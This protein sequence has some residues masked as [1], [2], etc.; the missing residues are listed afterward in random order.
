MHHYWCTA[1]SSVTWQCGFLA[2]VFKILFRCCKDANLVLEESLWGPRLQANMQLMESR[3]YRVDFLAV[4][5]VAAVA[6]GGH[7]RRDYADRN[8]RDTVGV[9]L[10]RKISDT[11]LFAAEICGT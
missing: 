6:T 4:N 9:Q 10:K 1:V 5:G 7:R 3:S 11:A 8:M 2:V